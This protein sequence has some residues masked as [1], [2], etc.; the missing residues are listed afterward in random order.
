[1]QLKA[2]G[3]AI[4]GADSPTCAISEARYRAGRAPVR[5]LLDR[6][7]QDAGVSVLH[8]DAY[9]CKAG[10]CAVEQDGVSLYQDQGHLS[11][12]GSRQLGKSIDLAGL[13]TGLAR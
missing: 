11:N 8:L 1:M 9:L 13:V 3:K 7:S 6:V 2:E 5:S 10:T 4:F 12:D